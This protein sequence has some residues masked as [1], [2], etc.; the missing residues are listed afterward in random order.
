MEGTFCRQY[1]A[2]PVGPLYFW[3]C[4]PYDEDSKRMKLLTE[5]LK[6]KIPALY[7]SQE[8]EEQRKFVCKFFDPCGSWTWYVLEGSDRGNGDWLFYG[9]VDGMEKEWGYFT[10]SDLESVRG[11]LG[12]GIERDIYFEDEEVVK[13]A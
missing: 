6:K 3:G 5:A 9:L 7:S 12:I 10:L 2:N 11:P 13:Y 8:Q 4:C 1:H